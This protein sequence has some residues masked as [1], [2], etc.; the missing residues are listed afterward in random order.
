MPIHFRPAWRY[1]WWRHRNILD[2]FF[3]NTTH[4]LIFVG[5]CVIRIPVIP[6]IG[7][8][9]PWSPIVPV[10]QTVPN[11]PERRQPHPTRLHRARTRHAVALAL[12]SHLRPNVLQRKSKCKNINETE[13]TLFRGCTFITRCGCKSCS[14]SSCSISLESK[15]L[16]YFSFSFSLVLKSRLHIS[17]CATSR[18]LP[19]NLR[20]SLAIAICQRDVRALIQN[21]RINLHIK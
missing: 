17:S 19:V 3:T 5:V 18:L 6:C 1:L 2:R 7:H 15:R 20:N 13:V 16:I 4:L 11:H 12:L 9:Y 14:R 8:H 10:F 21:R